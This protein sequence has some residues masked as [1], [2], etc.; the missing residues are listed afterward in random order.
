MTVRD[1]LGAVARCWYVF[2]AVMLGFGAL[3][4]AFQREGGSFYTNTTITFTLPERPTLLPD[5]GMNDLSVIAFAS[6]VAVYVNEGKPVATYSSAQAPSYGAG[7]REGVAVSLRND[8]NQWMTSFP[9]ATI[10]IQIVGPTYA[11][12]EERQSAILDEVIEVTRGQ[13]AAQSTS[14]ADQITAVIAPLSTEIAQVTASRSA[15]ILAVAAMTTAGVLTATSACV[16]VDRVLRRAGH[17]RVSS[18]RVGSSTSRLR[19]QTGG[20]SA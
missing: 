6:T 5:S 12:V 4:V 10:D 19:V 1:V 20:I 13:Q 7:V 17:R 9:N 14:A 3:T 11:W 18:R 16:T 8:G 15:Q 2:L